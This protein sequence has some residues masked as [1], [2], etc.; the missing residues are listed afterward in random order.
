MGW[1]NRLKKSARKATVTLS[2]PVGYLDALIVLSV[3]CDGR[4]VGKLATGQTL[5]FEAAPGE[6]VLL[7]REMLGEP[8]QIDACKPMRLNL[9]AGESRRFQVKYVGQITTYLFPILT[10]F[11]ADRRRRFWKRF[12]FEQ[13]F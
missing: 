3:Y 9:R 7:M 13:T 10:W 11:S 1:F 2:R 5:T 4:R 8:L 6:R 12:A